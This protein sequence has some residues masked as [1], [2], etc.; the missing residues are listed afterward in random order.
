MYT[1]SIPDFKLWSFSSVTFSLVK[2]LF[3]CVLVGRL[4][5]KFPLFFPFP[6]NLFCI[7]TWFFFFLCVCEEVLFF[8]PIKD[9]EINF[10][11]QI[12]QLYLW[13]C[14]HRFSD[15]T[16]YFLNFAFCL[17]PPLLHLFLFNVMKSCYG[18]FSGDTIAFIIYTNFDTFFNSKVIVVSNV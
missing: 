6:F 2:N 10:A 17:L 5:S 4:H 3:Q 8:F 7:F 13:L 16:K 14:L 18:S 11:D 1:K 9:D 15:I 12:N